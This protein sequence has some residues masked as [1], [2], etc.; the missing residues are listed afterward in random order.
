MTLRMQ[1]S[2][3]PI[4]RRMAFWNPKKTALDIGRTFEHNNGVPSTNMS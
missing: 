3:T 2:Q 4:M 1:G